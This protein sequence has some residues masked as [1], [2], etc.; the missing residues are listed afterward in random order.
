MNRKSPPCNQPISDKVSLCEAF[1]LLLSACVC[2]LSKAQS[3]LAIVLTKRIF[4]APLHQRRKLTGHAP[5]FCF[6]LPPVLPRRVPHC[7]VVAVSGVSK[8]KSY[9]A[10]LPSLASCFRRSIGRLGQEINSSSHQIQLP[11]E[12]PLPITT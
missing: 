1:L 5:S 12:L 4:C 3:R 10:S 6:P 2:M 8:C 9:Q 11:S 7:L